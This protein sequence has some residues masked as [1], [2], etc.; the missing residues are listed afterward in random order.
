M[1]TRFET[2]RLDIVLDPSCTDSVIWGRSLTL[3]ALVVPLQH[4]R[5]VILTPWGVAMTTGDSTFKST[6]LNTKLE[7][8]T[9]NR[10]SFV[11]RTG[12]MPR[13]T[14][15]PTLGDPDAVLRSL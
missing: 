2:G 7:R 9:I 5:V 15:S 1:I 3:P 13:G 14:G 4:G 12:L 6:W 8:S 10:G 11:L